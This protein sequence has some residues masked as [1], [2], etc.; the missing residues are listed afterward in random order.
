MYGTGCI[1][2]S[3]LSPRW[4]SLLHLS[5][6]F[7]EIVE[8]RDRLSLQSSGLLENGSRGRS[9]LLS[10]SSIDILSIYAEDPFSVSEIHH[11]PFA[12]LSPLSSLPL[13]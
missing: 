9:T 10:S 12:F 13:I 2:V 3:F 11:P 6:P 8:V 4:H 5:L 1:L 7:A